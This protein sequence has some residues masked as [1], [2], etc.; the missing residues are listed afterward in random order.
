MPTRK[1]AGLVLA[2]CANGMVT[3]QFVDSLANTFMDEIPEL[4]HGGT[5]NLIAGPGISGARNRM[6]R[7]FL[8][9]PSGA[10]WLLMID[11]DMVWHPHHI[12]RLLEVADPMH[13]PVVG[14][15]C[16][17]G[18][19][20]GNFFP[21]MYVLVDDAE[22][23]PEMG[24]CEKYPDAAVVKVDGTGA[25]FMLMHKSALEAVRREYP[26]PHP[27]FQE[28]VW[29]GKEMGEDL[30]FCLR[31]NTLGLP[32]HVDTSVKIGHVKHFVLTEDHYQSKVSDGSQRQ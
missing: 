5:I 9:H 15:L 10:E 31:L 23:H 26:E 6:V 17:G 22:G 29:Y 27:W 16:F 3:S 18:G 32:L 20:D 11:S 25:A 1:P 13:R 12:R 7:E 30:T 19:R 21:T 2:W 24:R 28:T 8:T 4:K 14:G